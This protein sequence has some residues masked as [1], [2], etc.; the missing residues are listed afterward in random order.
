MKLARTIDIND[1]PTYAEIGKEF[2]MEMN[3][4]FKINKRILE[5]AKLMLERKGIKKEDFFGEEK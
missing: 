3:D 4:V 2:D 5:K 1:D